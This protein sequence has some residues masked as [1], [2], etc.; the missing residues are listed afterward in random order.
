MICESCKL[1]GHC[2][3]AV[4]GC[5]CDCIDGDKKA[6]LIKEAERLLIAIPKEGGNWLNAGDDV[7]EIAIQG[8]QA[9]LS[10]VAGLQ[11][12]DTVTATM[13]KLADRAFIADAREAGDVE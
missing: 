13:T 5:E 12:V 7:V 4:D 6:L 2:Y 11:D 1:G 3:K 9:M 8:F 10:L